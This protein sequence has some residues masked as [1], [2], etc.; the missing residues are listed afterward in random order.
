MGEAIRL[1]EREGSLADCGLMVEGLNQREASSPGAGGAGEKSEESAE[2]SE[3][4]K[5]PGG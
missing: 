3:A 5:E 2:G 4:W 1:T